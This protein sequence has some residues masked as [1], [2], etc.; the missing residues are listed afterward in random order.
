[1]TLDDL[2]YFYIDILFFWQFYFNLFGKLRRVSYFIAVYPCL[3]KIFV[4]QILC[5]R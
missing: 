2:F 4:D 3:D 1:M 5:T